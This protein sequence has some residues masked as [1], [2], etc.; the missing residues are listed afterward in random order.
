[1][2]RKNL[3]NRF[4]LALCTM[5]V[6]IMTVFSSGCGNKTEQQEADHS[7]LETTKEDTQKMF[8]DGAVIGKGKTE[9]TLVVTNNEDT[10][11]FTVKT[12]EKT[13]GAALVECGLIEGEEGDYGLFV[14]T[15]N[16]VKVD[17]EKD[18]TYWAFYI[19]D[20]YASTGIELT[21]IEPSATYTLKI[22]K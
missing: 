1:M 2:E 4:L 5:L 21:N 20:E 11:T 16:G 12:D 19:N 13:V 15:V 22:E 14:N 3:K 10:R 18:K 7:Q 9:F 8:E 17:Y 6:M